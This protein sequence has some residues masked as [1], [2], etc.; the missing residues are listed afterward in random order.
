[1][2]LPELQ[3]L[4]RHKP[5]VNPYLI[6]LWA[7]LGLVALVV[8]VPFLFPR[9]TISVDGITT[10][11]SLAPQGLATK[12]VTVKVTPKSSA[13][14]ANVRLDDKKISP[15]VNKD[16]T[17]TFVLGAGLPDG[18]HTLTVD[19]GSRILWRAAPSE[20]LT[21]SVD[22]VA[23]T[24]TATMGKLPAT[25]DDQVT[26]TGSTETGA[27]LQLNGREIPVA[28]DGQF[29]TTL[30]RAPIGA[31][32]F[33]AQD[34]A[35]NQGDTMLPGLSGQLFPS[36]RAV[37]VSSAAWSYK[38][39]HD[40]IVKL[41]DEGKI[42][43]VELDIKDEG[44]K[45]GHKSA[46][47]L[48]I[49]IG[50]TENLYDLKTEVAGLKARGVRV[51]ARLVVFRD[52]VLSKAAW[53]G[54]QPDQ[55]LQNSDGTPYAGKYGGFT[56]PFNKT[57]RDYNSAIALEAAHA[58]VDAI[59]LDYIRRPEAKIENLKFPETTGE[60]TKE[61]VSDEIV[62]YVTELGLMLNETPARLG[63]SVFG[64]AVNEGENIAQ[65]V[66]KLATVT[67]FVAPM[68]Y[69]SA[70]TKGQFGVADPPAQPYDMVSKSLDAFKTS[71]KGSGVRLVPWLQDFNLY[72]T[73][74]TKDVRA[75]IDAAADIC[76]GDFMM[77]DPKVTYNADAL[78]TK[79]VEPKTGVTC[80]TR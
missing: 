9:H 54:K 72:R 21:F 31:F 46:V 32:R 37:H 76:I 77:W 40:G 53:Q 45:V 39:L 61:R 66:P 49:Q 50:A 41:I 80:P 14:S 15:Q 7:A 10:G 79:T 34:A 12:V 30:P 20:E 1:M 62:S 44:G 17:L 58:G 28:A 68:V 2:L 26:I 4:H 57:V 5:P 27:T 33:V 71:V 65:N 67:D 19:S 55:V 11:Q 35:G 38:P 48:A 24:I 16:G 3:T 78:P 22:S 59:I 64:V 56:N 75:Q 23:P 6:G 51:I 25:L 60:M 29:T 74:G 43:T 69:P 52:P 47:P 42:D 63:V 8:A 13:A 73:Y 18:S 36:T 70:W